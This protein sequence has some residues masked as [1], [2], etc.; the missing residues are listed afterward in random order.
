AVA[1]LAVDQ[2]AARVG[3]AVAESENLALDI[4][5][6]QLLA[7]QR[8]QL[9]PIGRDIAKAA[10]GNKALGIVKLGI[11]GMVGDPTRA[12]LTAVADRGP[13]QRVEHA[14][15]TGGDTGEGG[16]IAQGIAA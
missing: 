7:A 6:C 4:E 1:D 11:A 3:A 8:D 16:R 14:F 12:K 2:R 5:E 13:A 10:D 9:R 15:D